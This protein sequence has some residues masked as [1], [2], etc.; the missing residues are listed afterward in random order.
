MRSATGGR[1]RDRAGAAR[2]AVLGGVGIV[3]GDGAGRAVP[4][5][6]ERRPAGRVAQRLGIAALAPSPQ[7]A[8][9]RSAEARSRPSPVSSYASGAG[10]PGTA[11]S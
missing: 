9:S 2:A 8:S 7:S 3:D 11:S 1:W 4:A 10:A 5:R 6:L